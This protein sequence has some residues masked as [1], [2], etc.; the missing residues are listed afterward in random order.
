MKAFMV[1]VGTARCSVERGI[2]AEPFRSTPNFG[3]LLLGTDRIPVW[4]PAGSRIEVL[5]HVT[6]GN[7][8]SLDDQVV[9][10]LEPLIIRPLASTADRSAG[11]LLFHVVLAAGEGVISYEHTEGDL[12]DFDPSYSVLMR[13]AA[14]GRAAL[15]LCQDY[16]LRVGSPL[17]ISVGKFDLEL[18]YD[19]DKVESVPTAKLVPAEAGKK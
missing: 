12:V 15:I 19:S 14:D 5:T 17:R 18:E 1:Q 9:E 7:F 3:E 11:W 16:M 2:R 8:H 10:P 13:V 6:L 4:G